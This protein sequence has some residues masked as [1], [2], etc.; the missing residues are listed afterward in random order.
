[1]RT[2]ADVGGQADAGHE[3]RD[4]AASEA[5]QG[6]AAGCVL[7]PSSS[8]RNAVLLTFV[9]GPVRSILDFSCPELQ[10]NKLQCLKPLN[11]WSFVKAAIGS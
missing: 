2:Q 5:A 4:G 6:E 10:D 3:P 9:L 7:A 8:R 11:L 1:M